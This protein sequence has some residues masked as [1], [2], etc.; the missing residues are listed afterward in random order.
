MTKIQINAFSGQ[1]TDYVWHEI[2]EISSQEFKFLKGIIQNSQSFA[3]ENQLN[4]FPSDP[5]KR[6]KNN[7]KSRTKC[8][9]VLRSIHGMMLR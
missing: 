3:E 1:T 2:G 8:S 9:T 7:T 6:L 5:E 4:T